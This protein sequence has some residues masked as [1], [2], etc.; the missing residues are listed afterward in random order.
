[1]LTRL[2]FHRL[3]GRY[4][5]DYEVD[6]P[7]PREHVFDEPFVPRDVY[8]SDAEIGREVQV[9]ESEVN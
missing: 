2:R 9:R 8:N 3:V 4:Y 5:E 6:A 7:D 1:V